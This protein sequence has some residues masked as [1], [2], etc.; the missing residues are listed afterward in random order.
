MAQNVKKVVLVYLKQEGIDNGEKAKVR[1]FVSTNRWI[2]S[3]AVIKEATRETRIMKC[4]EAMK[5]NLKLQISCQK[6]N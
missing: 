3:A 4:K 5:L 6:G 1:N 2:K